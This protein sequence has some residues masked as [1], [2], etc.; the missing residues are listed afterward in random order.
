MMWPAPVFA[1]GK[2]CARPFSEEHL[3]LPEYL[4][5]LHDYEVI[6]TLNLPSYW[7]P[8]SFERAAE[9]CRSLMASPNERFFALHEQ[10]NE[11][12]IGTLRI[13]HIDWFCETG[14]IGIMI[15]K[16]EC[17][18]QGFAKDAVRSAATY[19]FQELGLRRLTAGAMSINVPMIAVFEG[20]GFRREGCFRQH[21]RLREGGYCDHIFFGCFPGELSLPPASR[22]GRHT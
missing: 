5:W 11:T 6:R 4:G 7:Q 10:A 12:F 20:L 19:A 8:I 21:D 2:S 1:G 17:W 13:G 16:R 3:R 15:G 18:G 14:D 22:E 9:Y